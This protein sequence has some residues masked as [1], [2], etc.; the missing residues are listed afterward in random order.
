MLPFFFLCKK[1]LKDTQYTDMASYI[2]DTRSFKAEAAPPSRDHQ[3][4]GS[5]SK[6]FQLIFFLIIQGDYIQPIILK[7]TIL[8]K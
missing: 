7:C 8:F 6:V 1:T 2:S 4:V 5:P 3:A